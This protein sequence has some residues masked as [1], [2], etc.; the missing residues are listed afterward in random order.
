MQLIN[1]LTMLNQLKKEIAD[2]DSNFA[3]FYF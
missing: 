3:I 1:K 2:K